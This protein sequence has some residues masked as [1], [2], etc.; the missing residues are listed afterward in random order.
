MLRLWQ[1]WL[2]WMDL[3]FYAHC[4]RINN[5][6]Y[7]KKLKKL[8]HDTKDTMLIIYLFVFYKI[9]LRV[10]V[11]PL[12]HSTHTEHCKS[13]SNWPTAIYYFIFMIVIKNTVSYIIYNLR[14]HH[15]FFNDGLIVQYYCVQRV[16]TYY[17]IFI[18]IS[19][20]LNVI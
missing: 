20:K 4:A 7:E 2:R 16:D 19:F 15:L 17:S 1:E 12:S 8:L 10:C 13:F 6:I 14:E 11:L 5:V 9:L 3:I 18:F